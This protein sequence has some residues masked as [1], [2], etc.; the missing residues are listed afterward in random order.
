MYWGKP[1]LAGHARQQRS[2]SCTSPVKQTADGAIALVGKAG[3]ARLTSEERGE[4]TMASI[5]LTSFSLPELKQLQKDV[6]HAI[7]G[8]SDR[9]K[10]EAISALEIKAQELGFNL[11]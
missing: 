2:G 4:Y 1:G 9:Q 7:D 8:Y 5:D 10:Q 11:L 6:K 3:V